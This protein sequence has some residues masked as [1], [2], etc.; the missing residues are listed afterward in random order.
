MET[1]K[2]WLQRWYY[3]NIH[4]IR[5]RN[6]L[7]R[8]AWDGTIPEPQCCRVMATAVAEGDSPVAYEPVFRRWRL[9]N[10][11]H[12]M[13]TDWQIEFCPWCG[14]RL[15]GDLGAEWDE[16]IQKLGFTDIGHYSET[17]ELPEDYRTDRWWKDAGL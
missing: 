4:P 6:T 11:Y 10:L 5:V 9:L 7:D 15:P 3:R 8:S 2:A 13:L 14:H 16:R 1:P 12:R 17:P